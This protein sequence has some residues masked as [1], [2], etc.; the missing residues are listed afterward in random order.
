VSVNTEA[1]APPSLWRQQIM[2][3]GKSLATLERNSNYVRNSHGVN[4]VVICGV[5]P[6][7]R[8]LIGDDWAAGCAEHQADDAK[9]D[10][11]TSLVEWLL[12]RAVIVETPEGV[13]G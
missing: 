5:G 12:S 3:S 9:L 10:D 2:V 8:P 13:E 7:F 6:Y 4:C 11:I 1:P